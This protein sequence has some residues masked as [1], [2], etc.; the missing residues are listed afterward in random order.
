ML[1]ISYPFSDSW[2]M[3]KV[4]SMSE[5]LLCDTL[6]PTPLLC[7]TLLCCS[8]PPARALLSFQGWG[9]FVW[10]TTRHSR[11]GSRR[12]HFFSA[13]ASQNSVQ[14]LWLW[15]PAKSRLASGEL[16]WERPSYLFGEFSGIVIIII[17]S[18]ALSCCCLLNYC[19]EPFVFELYFWCVKPGF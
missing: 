8:F 2:V 12:E 19:V 13:F 10:Q 4:P 3:P 5:A 18:F 6:V 16:H 9:L 1:Q 14:F 15:K 11:H 17:N 7:P